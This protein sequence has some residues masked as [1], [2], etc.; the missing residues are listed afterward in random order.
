MKS[1]YCEKDLDP[2]NFL[3]LT[4]TIISS[5]SLNGNPDFIK[6]RLYNREIKEK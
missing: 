3:P 5:S 2:F 4:F 1:Y 6:F